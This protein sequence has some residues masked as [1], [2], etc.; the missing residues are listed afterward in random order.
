MSH[1]LQ[2][3][4]QL[5]DVALGFNP[6]RDEGQG[7]TTVDRTYSI[8]LQSSMQDQVLPNCHASVKAAQH[9]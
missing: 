5:N 2:C 3:D 8:A 7:M 9:R 6:V 4:L 1:S